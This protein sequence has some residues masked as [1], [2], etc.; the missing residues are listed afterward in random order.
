MRKASTRL[1]EQ[2]TQ[3]R[4][5]LRTSSPLKTKINGEL[6]SRLVQ[7]TG[8]LQPPPEIAL[9][10]DDYSSAKLARFGAV[11]QVP[12]LA[13]RTP[14]ILYWYRTD[15][16]SSGTAKCSRNSLARSPMEYSSSP[17][18]DQAGDGGSDP[19]RSGESMKWTCMSKLV[20]A[21]AGSSSI[22]GPGLPSSMSRISRKNPRS[23]LAC[24][25]ALSA[26]FLSSSG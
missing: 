20:A 16:E 2:G 15:V 14:L 18:S 7:Q 10:S 11:W 12:A 9:N 23:Q 25:R 24:F 3:S 8:A 6:T 13:G 26:I 4:P 1:P 5:L 21:S 22:F 17:V 19:F